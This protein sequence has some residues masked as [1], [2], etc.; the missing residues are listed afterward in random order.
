MKASTDLGIRLN[1]KMVLH[2]N[3]LTNPKNALNLVLNPL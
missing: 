2:L 3:D 1:R